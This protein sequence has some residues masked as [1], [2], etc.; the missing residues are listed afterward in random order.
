MSQWDTSSILVQAPPQIR[1]TGETAPPPP[2]EG[3]QI[4]GSTSLSLLVLIFQNAAGTNSFLAATRHSST[5]FSQ[6]QLPE[7]MA[8][9]RSMA[10][11]NLHTTTSDTGDNHKQ[12]DTGWREAASVHA[13]A[14][15]VLRVVFKV[16]DPGARKAHRYY[17]AILRG[18]G[19]DFHLAGGHVR[20]D[21]DGAYVADR[22]D[23]APFWI[24]R[25]CGLRDALHAVNSFG[26]R[27]RRGG[28][29][30]TVQFLKGRRKCQTLWRLMKK[31]SSACSSAPER[32]GVD[33]EEPT[34][35]AEA[36][37]F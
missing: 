2:G 22:T 26:P 15:K 4:E 12:S 7:G 21:C 35:S 37:R 1:I 31:R 16:A 10:M 9:F 5:L 20:V 13:E 11:I 8:D 14:A 36:P 17:R 34:I 29:Y 33:S 18:P 30:I 3:G 27:R 24:E 23:G 32:S 28:A 6:D 19:G 25:G